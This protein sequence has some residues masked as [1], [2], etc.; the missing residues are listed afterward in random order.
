MKLAIL[1]DQPHWTGIGLY[2]LEL[3]NSVRPYVEDIKL[4][5]LGAV[6]DDFPNSQIIGYFKQTTHLLARPL[7]IRNNYNRLLNDG[8]YKNYLFHFVG[9]DFFGVGKRPGIM[10]VHDV[11][12]DRFLTLN[13]LNPKKA[14]GELERIRK[15][16]SALNVA[17]DAIAIISI[18]ERTRNELKRLTGLDSEV[19]YHWIED[20]KFTTR[21]ADQCL[22]KL[23]LDKNYSYILS[24]GNDRPNK[25]IDLIEAFSNSLPNQYKLIKI[26]S[27]INSLNC[28]N[29]GQV[30]DELY[31]FYFNA[32]KAYLHLS[33]DEGF[34]RPLIE[35]LGSEIPVICRDTEINNELL[36][37]ASII[38][39]DT[40]NESHV[41]KVIEKLENSSVSYDLAEK[42]QLRKKLF[43]KRSI[44]NKYLALYVDSWSYFLKGK[45]IE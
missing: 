5:Y 6:K 29:M 17:N 1:V 44:I 12:K 26:G 43:K 11:I 13:N 10:T 40:V 18:S 3:Y 38:I 4:F 27:T 42:I 33:D 15:Y 19:I 9:T 28:I 25:R 36:G 39:S 20:E 23:G 35:A 41:K 30:S 37:N 32:A 31:P 8:T 16:S 21:D 22:Q 2:A 14:L 24:V 45:N 34:G 7:I